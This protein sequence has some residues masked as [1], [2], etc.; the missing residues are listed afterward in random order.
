MESVYLLVL[1][2]VWSCGGLVKSVGGPSLI[3]PCKAVEVKGGVVGV[4]VGYRRVGI[5]GAVVGAYAALA[6]HWYNLWL[7]RLVSREETVLRPAGSGV[8]AVVTMHDVSHAAP[9]CIAR[10]T[11]LSQWYRLHAVEIV[12]I[13]FSKDGMSEK[14]HW[15]SLRFGFTRDQEVHCSA[16][17]IG[18]VY[19]LVLVRERSRCG[20]VNSVA[21]KALAR[22]CKSR[23][24]DGVEDVRLL[25]GYA[26]YHLMENVLRPGGFG[27]KAVVGSHDLSRPATMCVAVWVDLSQWY[28]FYAVE[29][30]GG[31]VVLALHASCELA[32]MVL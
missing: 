1:V 6:E 32:L 11:D 29:V 21:G 24:W 30:K 26:S 9:M 13:G 17:G 18:D 7:R 22:I 14:N 8:K 31:N 2:R 4:D 10:R 3:R 5:D 19:W 16:F 12:C 23:I 25:N 20:L 28:R 27:V 15:L